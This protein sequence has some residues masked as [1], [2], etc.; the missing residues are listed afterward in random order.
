MLKCENIQ[1]N[2]YCGVPPLLMA[3]SVPTSLAAPSLQLTKIRQEYIRWDE[4]VYI[5]CGSYG[6]VFEVKFNS[7]STCA[8]EICFPDNAVANTTIIKT[9]FLRLCHLWSTL[10]HPNLVQFLGIYYPVK[11]AETGLS[12]MILEKM[13]SS[14]MSLL[15]EYNNIPLSVKVSILHDTSLGL[16]YLHTH[17]PPIVHYDLSTKNIMLTPYL[18]AKITD[19]FVTKTLTSQL[20]MIENKKKIPIKAA[21]EKDMCSFGEVILHIIT[22]QQ[23]TRGTTPLEDG[24]KVKW[25]HKC[26]DMITGDFA[27]DLRD[28]VT[29][30]FEPENRPFHLSLA[31][32]WP[33]ASRLPVRI[34]GIKE[35]CRWNYVDGG[36]DPLSWL[37]EIKHL[38]LLSTHTQLQVCSKLCPFTRMHDT[39]IFDLL[40]NSSYRIP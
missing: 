4:K 1:E 21:L 33:V 23:P 38:S 14:V 36:K 28:L 32:L 7:T 6:R 2:T 27:Q 16:E 29:L 18:K 34:K 20:S 13:H 15:Q 26:M 30:C 35:R 9:D 37:V 17:N 24:H 40:I 19:P 11:D 3:A 25:Y 10:H 12:V 22:Y 31:E 5:G 39:T 8:K